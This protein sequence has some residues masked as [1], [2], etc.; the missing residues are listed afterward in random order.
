MSNCTRE[1]ELGEVNSCQ[2]EGSCATNAQVSC[3]NYVDPVQENLFNN[4]IEV[5]QRIYNEKKLM[6]ENEKNYREF[7]KDFN[8]VLW[9]ISGLLIGTIIGVTVEKFLMIGADVTYTA[10]FGLFLGVTICVNKNKA[11][12][13]RYADRL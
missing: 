3:C 2:T 11:K 4:S 8:P 6:V 7:R 13:Q 9:G 1:N 10:I 12:N 5:K